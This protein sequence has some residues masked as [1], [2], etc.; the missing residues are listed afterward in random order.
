MK[1]KKKMRHQT[2]GTNFAPVSPDNLLLHDRR[3]VDRPIDGQPTT[4]H[5]LEAVL[6]SRTIEYES[7]LAPP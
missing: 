2:T 5:R 3:A 7:S 6:C 1:L 4:Q